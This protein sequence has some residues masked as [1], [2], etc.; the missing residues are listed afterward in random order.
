ML[1]RLKVADLSVPVVHHPETE[2]EAHCLVGELKLGRSIDQPNVDANFLEQLPAQSLVRLLVVLDMTTREVP[3]VRVPQPVRR[4]VPQQHLVLPPQGRNSNV[5]SAHTGMIVEPLD[6][7]PA[8]GDPMASLRP[9]Q[10]ASS[11]GEL[12]E[13]LRSRRGRRRPSWP[14]RARLEVLADG[15]PFGSTVDGAEGAAQGVEFGEGGAVGPDAFGR[16]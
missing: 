2:L 16:A 5:M 14:L 6:A 7:T 1:L 13:V 4:P 11:A 12:R 10:C 8:T 9:R 15:V 3:D